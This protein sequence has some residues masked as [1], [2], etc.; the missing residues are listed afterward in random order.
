MY[1][2]SAA[3][4]VA[5]SLHSDKGDVL[6]LQLTGTKHWEM[7]P[8]LSYAVPMAAQMRGKKGDSI[9][10]V[11]VDGCRHATFTL[12]P[13]TSPPAAALGPFM[14]PLRTLRPLLWLQ[15][16]SLRRLWLVVLV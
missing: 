9:R 13:V 8:P 5:T 14:S 1:V 10:E 6:I 7:F 3:A 16:P 11:E 15:R 4:G 12:R 2:T